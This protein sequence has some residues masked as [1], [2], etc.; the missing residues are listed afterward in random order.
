MYQSNILS[1]EL[2]SGMARLLFGIESAIS[3]GGWTQDV[4]EPSPLCE[5][6]FW[7]LVCRCA[8]GG[9]ILSQTLLKDACGEHNSAS[10][11]FAGVSAVFVSAA[12]KSI[13]LA[14]LKSTCAEAKVRYKAS[15]LAVLG[16]AMCTRIS[17]SLA[18]FMLGERATTNNHLWLQIK[19]LQNWKPC[20]PVRYEVVLV[21]ERERVSFF[22]INDINHINQQR[23]C[24]SQVSRTEYFIDAYKLQGSFC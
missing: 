16:A 23:G 3:L 13:L 18:I 10:G 9:R 7:A 8:G 22:T 14:G 11:S 5:S 15:S 21:G 12:G 2:N 19:Q 1:G 17:T 6:G 4:C 20:T 24:E